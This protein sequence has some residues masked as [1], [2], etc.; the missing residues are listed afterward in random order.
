MLSNSKKTE[1]RL[2][3]NG[4]TYSKKS[5]CPVCPKCEKD[6]KSRIN[7]LDLLSAPAR[8]ALENENIVTLEK[9]ATYS[10]KEILKL[11]GLGKSTI[12]TLQKML[13]EQNL[14]FRQD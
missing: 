11:H 3:V 4:H 10:Q 2:C 9:L 14:F 6:N 1:L 13:A 8:R 7:F 12:P 5:D